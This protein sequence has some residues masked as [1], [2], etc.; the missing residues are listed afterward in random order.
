MVESNMTTKRQMK[1]FASAALR[2]WLRMS[3]ARQQSAARLWHHALLASSLRFRLPDSAVVLGRA[4]VF[5]TGAVR[6]GEDALLYPHVHLETQDSAEIFFGDRVVLSRGVHVVAM[7]GI[8]IG[9]GTMIGEYSSIRDANHLREPG[10]ALR[11]SGYEAQPIV[12]GDDVWIGRGVAILRGV[13]VGDGATVGANAVVTH[14]V[15]AGVVVG[16]VPARPLSRG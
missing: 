10:R 15:P 2:G 7:A 6:F 11:E 13:T 12:I 4:Y 16:G 9:R 5:G 8:R 1:A 3:S 14:D